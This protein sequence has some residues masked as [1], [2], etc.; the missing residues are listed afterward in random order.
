MRSQSENIAAGSATTL[1]WRRAACGGWRKGCEGDTR[2]L[3]K[4]ERSLGTPYSC[5]WGRRAI[6]RRIATAAAAAGTRAARK[7]AGTGHAQALAAALDEGSP[8]RSGRAHPAHGNRCRSYARR[9]R[10]RLTRGGDRAGVR[11]HRPLARLHQQVVRVPRP[12][13]MGA[14]VRSFADRCGQMVAARGAEESTEWRQPVDLVA[15]GDEAAGE[16]P[17]LFAAGHGV[18]DRSDHSALARELHGD[19]PHRIIDALKAAIGAGVAPSDLSR[20]LA[21][22]AALRAARR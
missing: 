20:S 17:A 18:R 13:W 19:D 2:S 5:C 9:A 16:L 3:T 8:S 10:R 12:D 22:A 11:R 4:N 1:R 21:Y 14:R 6:W 15:P 7:P